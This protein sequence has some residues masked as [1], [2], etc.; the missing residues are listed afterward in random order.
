MWRDKL[1]ANP[2]MVVFLKNVLLLLLWEEWLHSVALA[3]LHFE[4]VRGMIVQ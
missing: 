3:C 1:L 2:F 4:V